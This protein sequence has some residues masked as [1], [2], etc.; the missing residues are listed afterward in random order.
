MTAPSKPPDELRARL[1]AEQVALMLEPLNQE[2]R[3]RALAAA[4]CL[5]DTKAAARVIRVFMDEP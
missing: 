2:T 5:T 3:V 4:I 1:A